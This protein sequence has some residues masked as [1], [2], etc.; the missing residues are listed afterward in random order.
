M[1]MLDMGRMEGRF[2][3]PSDNVTMHSDELGILILPWTSESFLG[4]HHP[5]SQTF[6][7][8]FALLCPPC[9]L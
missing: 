7:L 2:L 5:P 3:Q 6:S 1:D 4:V 9:M 8:V